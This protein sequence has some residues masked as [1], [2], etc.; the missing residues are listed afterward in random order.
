MLLG[1][2]HLAERA[3][4]ILQMNTELD[5]RFLSECVPSSNLADIHIIRQQ[6]YLTD[7]LHLPL[8]HPLPHPTKHSPSSALSA[9]GILPLPSSSGYSTSTLPTPPFRLYH[10]QHHPRRERRPAHQRRKIREPCKWTKNSNGQHR[11]RAR[12]G[13]G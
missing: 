10:Q 2:T 11:R 9:C 7:M 1:Y 3:G 5:V 4:S 13:I 8:K 12:R 6:R